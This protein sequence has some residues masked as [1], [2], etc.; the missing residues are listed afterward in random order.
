MAPRVPVPSP[1][2]A[3]IYCTVFAFPWKP[4]NAI[5]THKRLSLS[6]SSSH[7]PTTSSSR[8]GPWRRRTP[9]PAP[10]SAVPQ[11]CSP[12]PADPLRLPSREDDTGWAGPCCRDEP[13][14]SREGCTDQGTTGSLHLPSAPPRHYLGDI[15]QLQ[16]S[17]STRTDSQVLQNE[18][19][20]FNDRENAEEASQAVT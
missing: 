7:T 20:E 8:A 12:R 14:L 16:R 13:S 6:S 11:G 17:D 4:G 19:W 1:A 9:V 18:Q 3:V 2:M 5:K 10:G 15:G